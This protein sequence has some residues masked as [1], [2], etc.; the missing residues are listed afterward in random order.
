M[1][2]LPGILLAGL[3]AVTAARAANPFV[4]LPDKRKIEGTEVRATREG[5]IYLTTPAGRMEYPKGTKVVMDQP[6][7]LIKA[8]ELFRKNQ[9][10]EAIPILEKVAEETRF[11]GWDLKARTLLALA[12]SGKGDW[13]KAVESFESLM[14]DFKEGGADETVRVGYLQALA[15]SGQ[16]EKVA[17]LLETAIRKGTRAEA[18]E[19]QLIRGKV[20]L[21][22]GDPE[23]AL[24]DFMRTAVFFKEFKA[25]ASEAMFLMAGCFEKLGQ[26][27]KADQA[28][29]Q[30]VQEFPDSGFAAQA[31]A[32]TGIKP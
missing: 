28:Y 19:A 30:M 5:V 18:A 3:L 11:L 32:K 1:K 9:F 26:A 29:R 23:S 4:E 31:R 12:Q 17:P 2:I 7:D 13:K 6:A 21:E 16:K 27:E 24:F 10:A 14:A 8:D 15:L 25:P 22:A 20:S